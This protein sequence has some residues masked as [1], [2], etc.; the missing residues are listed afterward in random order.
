[1]LSPCSFSRR[2]LCPIEAHSV[3][4]LN[5]TFGNERWA[6]PR[7]FE[8]NIV[9]GPGNTRVEWIRVYTHRARGSLL[10]NPPQDRLRTTRPHIVSGAGS[11]TLTCT[12]L[13]TAQEA[14]LRTPSPCR[15]L[16]RVLLHMAISRLAHQR[17]P[18]PRKSTP[19]HWIA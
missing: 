17:I 3:V 16:L 5:S 9:R 2:L 15:S 8:Y 7:Y 1:M 10:Q 19:K 14:P 6:F 13:V 12:G 11:T 18:T 4:M